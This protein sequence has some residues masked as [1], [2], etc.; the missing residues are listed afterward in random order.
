MDERIERVEAAIEAIK[1]AMTRME[2]RIAVLES[3]EGGAPVDPEED[4][5][6]VHPGLV[7]VLSVR[8]SWSACIGF[9]AEGAAGSRKAEVIGRWRIYVTGIFQDYKHEAK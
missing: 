6:G 7:P 5:G 3:A 1:G 4:T 9:V 8:F 2:G